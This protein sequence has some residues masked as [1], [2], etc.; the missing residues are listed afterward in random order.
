MDWNPLSI[1][2]CWVEKKEGWGGKKG[3]S[4]ASQR[5]RL[6]S[7]GRFDALT[8]WAQLVLMIRICYPCLPHRRQIHVERPAALHSGRIEG[9]PNASPQNMKFVFAI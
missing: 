2:T 5:S 3:S 1:F 6:D 4:A 7:I 9:N 8:R